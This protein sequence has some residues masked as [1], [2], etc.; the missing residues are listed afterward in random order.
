MNRAEYAAELL[1]RPSDNP[2]ISCFH[3]FK[4][5]PFLWVSGTKH[6]IYTDC[7][8]LQSLPG[9]RD[10]ICQQ[11]GWEIRGRG[12]KPDGL[13][14]VFSSAIFH[15]D[16]LAHLLGLPMITARPTLKD[17]GT[18]RAIDGLLIPGINY[19]VVDD[20][21]STG[22]SAIKA[23]QTVRLEGGIVTHALSIVTYG[24]EEAAKGFKNAEIIP[25]SL[26]DF[27]TILKKAFELEMINEKMAK[28]I[29]DWQKD[30]VG[31]S[32]RHG[33]E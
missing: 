7:R 31:W 19:L 9:A 29:S 13:A 33:F 16:G 17:H 3:F 1:L 8:I 11:M 14:A 15:T 18:A 12:I 26:V 2:E 30:P 21:F 25:I 23:A 6:P 4:D 28:V 20:L 32:K 10:M 5:K 22:S 27:S 24:W